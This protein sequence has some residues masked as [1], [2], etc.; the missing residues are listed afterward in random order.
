M[1]KGSCFCER[2][3]YQAGG[4]TEI[5]KCHCSKCRKVFGSASSA[6][7]LVPEQ[8]FRWLRGE[9]RITV[10]QS[11][12]GFKRFFCR[13]CGSVLPQFVESMHQWWIPVGTL[14]DDPGVP[15]AAHIYVDSK[16][17]WEVIADGLPQFKESFPE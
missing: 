5:F 4:F 6:A 14:D 7:S 9:D 3:Q 2:V 11:P 16:A 15:L 10:Y 1:I 8:E 17:P 13:D 12:S